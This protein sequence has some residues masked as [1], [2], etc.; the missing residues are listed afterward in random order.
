VDAGCTFDNGLF[1][2][3]DS[4]E[5][6]DNEQRTPTY[7]FYYY[8]HTKANE[9]LETFSNQFDKSIFVAENKTDIRMSLVE[10]S[11]TEP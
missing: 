7:T 3:A 8:V 10:A 5:S 6:R 1:K 9:G 11:T 4:I 2:V